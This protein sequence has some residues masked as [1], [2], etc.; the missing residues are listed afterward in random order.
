MKRAALALLL[1]TAWSGTARSN[2]VDLFGFGA[3]APAM[4]GAHT[5]ATEDSSANYYNPAALAASTRLHID[6]GYQMARPTLR[7]NGSSQ[8]VDTSRGLAAGLVVPGKWVGRQVAIGAALFLPDQSILTGRTLSAEHPRWAL[9]DNRPRR[10]FF[11][12]HAGLQLRDDLFVGAGVGTMAGTEGSYILGGRLGFPIPDDSQLVLDVDVDATSAVYPQAGVLWKATPWLDVGVTYRGQFVLESLQVV[13]FEADIGSPG[14]LAV[15]DAV[16]DIDT[17]SLD[18]FQPAQLAFGIAAQL[19]PRV[20]LAF[21]AVYQRWSGYDNPT[22]VIDI[23]LDVGQF[24]ELVML[25][26]QPNLEALRFHDTLSPRL[27]VEVLAASTPHTQWRARAGYAYDPSP[28]PEQVRSSNFIDNDKHTVS[29]G[30]GLRVANVTGLLPHPFELDA[31]AALTVLPSR[32]H[33]KLSPVDPTGD[34]SARGHIIAAGMT[35]RWTF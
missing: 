16:V 25:D 22:P 20:L 12:F 29:A 5:A 35:T 9:Y 7:M 2:P 8:G 3:R 17:V 27:G 24:N 13:R 32:T 15:E 6:I 34:I 11:G 10:L 4:G 33:R 31:Y 14:N 21:D 18:F 1:C 30:L 19:T 23:E 28:A 26:E